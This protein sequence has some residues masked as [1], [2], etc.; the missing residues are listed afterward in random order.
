M[1]VVIE[2][3]PSLGEVDTSTL[4]QLGVSA[5]QPI[6][7]PSAR[8]MPTNLQSLPTYFVPPRF[9]TSLGTTRAAERLHAAGMLPPDQLAV[10]YLTPNHLHGMSQ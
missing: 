10:G 2:P 8:P 7:V 3:I 9:Q 5:D 4:S 1:R 6:E